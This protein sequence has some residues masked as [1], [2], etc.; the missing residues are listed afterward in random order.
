MWPVMRHPAGLYVLFF[1]EMWERFSY[2]GMRALLLLYMI[3]ALHYSEASAGRVYGWY[4]A[5]VFVTPVFGGILADR[6][7]GQQ[8]SILWGASLMALGHFL[9]AW[10]SSA[11]F[12]GA[13]VL[14]VIGNG[15]FKPNISVIVGKLYEQDDSRRDAA[16]SLFYMGINL[17]A[18]LSPLICGTLGQKVGWHYGFAAAGLGMLL[19]LLIFSVGRKTLGEHG[20][21][22]VQNKNTVQSTQAALTRVQWQRLGVL[23][24]LGLVGNVVFW[25]AFEQAGSSL[26]LF[27]E[28]STNRTITS[29]DWVMPSSW[30]QA[31]NPLFIALVAPIFSIVWLKLAAYGREPSTPL[32]FAVGLMLLTCGFYTMVRAGAHVDAG[33]TVGMHWLMLAYF[34]NTCGELC[35]SPVGLSAVTKLTPAPLASVSMGL[36][37]GSMAVA[38]ELGGMFAGSYEQMSRAEFFWVPTMTAAGAAVLLLV[39]ARPLRRM[40]HGIS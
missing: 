27:A 16:F 17:G 1:T 28:E 34:F 12:I 21:H 22:P 10:P 25:A 23:F 5:A 19:G 20:L 33:Q 31:A 30:F 9:M 26:T 14:L 37:F 3:D 8:R 38:N 15:L 4:T 32:K 39:L 29:L 35:V 40:M 2:Y 7:L 36:W 24:L 13:L 18:F 6:Y 11:G